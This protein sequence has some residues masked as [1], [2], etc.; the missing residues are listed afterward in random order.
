M[1]RA[2]PELNT[3]LS[4]SIGA[5]AA[6]RRQCPG[7]PA[8][9]PFVPHRLAL[10]NPDSDSFTAEDI[11]SY[12][13]L[14]GESLDGARLCIPALGSADGTSRVPEGSPTLSPFV[15]ARTTQR[16]L[17]A[18]NGSSN[19]RIAPTVEFAHGL[20]R[21]K[22]GGVFVQREVPA[23]TLF[24]C[25][26]LLRDVSVD[27]WKSMHTGSS[28][29]GARIVPFVYGDKHYI[30]DMDSFVS[31]VTVPFESDIEIVRLRSAN[32][33]STAAAAAA[34]AAAAAASAAPTVT[35]SAFQ[36]CAS[37][38]H[39]TPASCVVNI[40]GL[41][42]L[43][44]THEACLDAG[45]RHNVPTC[46]PTH[47]PSNW[48]RNSS[49]KSLQQYVSEHKTLISGLLP[50]D[51]TADDVLAG[52]IPLP[53][54]MFVVTEP[55]QP[56]DEL[57]VSWTLRSA[58]QRKERVYQ[59]LSNCCYVE[60][61]GKRE[62]A[63]LFN[64]L[65]LL[66]LE[67]PDFMSS[68][69]VLK[70]LERVIS[71]VLAKEELSQQCDVSSSALQAMLRSSCDTVLKIHAMVATYISSQDREQ[72]GSFGKALGCVKHALSERLTRIPMREFCQQLV[73]HLGKSMV[74]RSRVF[75]NLFVR[76]PMDFMAQDG[77][78]VNL[79]CPFD[80]VNTSS[81]SST[82][83]R[84][85]GGRKRGSRQRRKDSDEP[86]TKQQARPR[87]RIPTYGGE[88]S[89]A[90]L[91]PR[92]GTTVSVSPPQASTV[93]PKGTVGSDSVEQQIRDAQGTIPKLL[94]GDVSTH[95]YAPD[96]LD[97]L[98]MSEEDNLLSA[99]F[100][101]DAFDCSNRNASP[102]GTGFQDVNIFQSMVS[103]RGDEGEFGESDAQ[104]RGI[105]GVHTP[106]GHESRPGASSPP[107]LTSQDA[108][109]A[110]GFT[111]VPSPGLT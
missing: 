39:P 108:Q 44:N 48:H 37:A 31:P 1:A 20:R 19:M 91:P 59:S 89:C 61:P 71:H 98:V 4:A 56:G 46:V 3:E 52:R 49:F 28:F 78:G 13:V 41:G 51:A 76:E 17:P 25:F 63:F 95:E 33:T 68:E 54:I 8:P 109:T 18:S 43:A 24:P 107:C 42:L 83:V 36:S 81:H 104:E 90:G 60:I 79:F 34:M 50:G 77:W 15:C 32:E 21:E 67:V 80:N 23:G 110:L 58:F 94:A 74:Q 93:Q 47:F 97:G 2:S 40:R 86:P 45:G 100:P 92:G 72:T 103:Q 35:S 9:K 85:R 53:A 55:L 105:P 75:Y 27:V 88:M 6:P 11:L 57:L 7:A 64:H 96:P 102:F 65:A 14:E 5:A 106:L 16:T 101:P 22:A 73:Y 29:R 82:G 10:L 12:K 38:K 87:G 66:L 70:R 26:G 69:G 62:S 84:G 30:L 111:V 99:L